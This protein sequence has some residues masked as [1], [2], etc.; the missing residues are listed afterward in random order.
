MTSIL[1]PLN[2]RT[3]GPFLSDCQVR[4]YKAHYISLYGTRLPEDPLNKVN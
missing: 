4:D 1:E 3:L 2:P